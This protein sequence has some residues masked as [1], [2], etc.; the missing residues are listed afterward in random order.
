ML[1]IN[2]DLAERQFLHKESTG[3]TENCKQQPE[4]GKK[5]SVRTQITRANQGAADSVTH[6]HSCDRREQESDDKESVKTVTTV[7]LFL[8]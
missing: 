3:D 8:H 7:T 2:M 5:Y 1:I 6:C 4:H